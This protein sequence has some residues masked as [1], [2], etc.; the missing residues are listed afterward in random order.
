MKQPPFPFYPSQPDAPVDQ[1]PADL[2]GWASAIAAGRTFLELGE[3]RAALKASGY[4][5]EPAL[6][7]AVAARERSLIEFYTAGQCAPILKP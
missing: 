3:L 1:T 4:A 7:L 2:A 5:D 6:A